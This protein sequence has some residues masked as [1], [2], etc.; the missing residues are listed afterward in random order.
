MAECGLLREV[1]GLPAGPNAPGFLLLD[2]VG[3]PAVDNDPQCVSVSLMMEWMSNRS[4]DASGCFSA[5]SALQRA[6]AERGLRLPASSRS[7]C[8]RVCICGDC[9]DRAECTTAPARERAYF[10][11]CNSIR[12]VEVVQRIK[13]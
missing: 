12:Q 7:T 11:V 3:C 2:A 6:K 5:T 10:L 9:C 8:L 1:A 4:A 13:R